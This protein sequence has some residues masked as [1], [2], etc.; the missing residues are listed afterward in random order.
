[1]HVLREHNGTKTEFYRTNTISQGL[2]LAHFAFIV[3]AVHVIKHQIV[4][5]NTCKINVPCWAILNIVYNDAMYTKYIIMLCKTILSTEMQSLRLTSEWNAAMAPS[6][7]TVLA[8]ALAIASLIL[9]FFYATFHTLF[10]RISCLPCVSYSALASPKSALSFQSLSCLPC[11]SYY[12]LV[13][14]MYLS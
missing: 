1:M 3:I 12:F 2:V 4:L 13:S 8:R 14:A 7:G 10:Q 11:V 5:I 9:P 6:T